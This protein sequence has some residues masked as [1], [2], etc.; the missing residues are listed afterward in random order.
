MKPKNKSSVYKKYVESI[1]DKI[2]YVIEN[3]ISKK[4]L[5]DTI[6][7]GW[8]LDIFKNLYSDLHMK[9]RLLRAK[10][11]ALLKDTASEINHKIAKYYK[12]PV[13]ITN[14][15]KKNTMLFLQ[16]RDK[17]YEG[18]TMLENINAYSRVTQA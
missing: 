17:S 16:R 6:D 9:Q 14:K 4:E 10:G 2:C 11:K 7:K 12:L 15:L 3:N 18:N 8:K 13:E 5:M 1:Y